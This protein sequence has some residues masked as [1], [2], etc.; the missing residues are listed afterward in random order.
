MHMEKQE[1]IT[2]TVIFCSLWVLADFVSTIFVVLGVSVQNEPSLSSACA[3]SR[4]APNARFIASITSGWQW[5]GVC[6]V[7]VGVCP[8]FCGTRVKAR[9]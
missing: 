8:V 3:V 6:G 1:G 9:Q 4:F 2:V 7:G 5:I